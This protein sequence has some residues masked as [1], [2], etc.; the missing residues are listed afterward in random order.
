MAISG[1]EE[2]QVI[3]ESVDHMEKEHG[4]QN[5]SAQYAKGNIRAQSQ[6]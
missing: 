1:D 5:F 4:K 2:N 6:D 3:G